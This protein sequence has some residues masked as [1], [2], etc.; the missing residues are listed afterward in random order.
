MRGAWVSWTA[1]V[2][3]IAVV[4]CS[5]DSSSSNGSGGGGGSGGTGTVEGGAG[6]AGAS[7]AGGS[8]GGDAGC[9]YSVSFGGPGAN[10]QFPRLA[11]DADGNLLV[12]GTFTGTVDFGGGPLS[13]PDATL[14]DGFLI[15]LDATG[16]HLWSQRVAASADAN[17]SKV[18]MSAEASGAVIVSFV[19]EGSVKIG[20]GP[21]LVSAGGT[22]IAVAKLSAAGEHEWS[23]QLGGSLEERGGAIAHASGG[24]ALHGHFLS[25]QLSFSGSLVLTNTTT[26]NS[27]VFAA[28]LDSDGN[29][30]WATNHGS[31]S[32]EIVYG[33]GN[34]DPAGN[35]IFMATFGGDLNLGSS[36]PAMTG[37]GSVIA[38]LS[39]SG[40]CMFRVHV[41]PQSGVSTDFIALWHAWSTS[42]LG[43]LVGGT[44]FGSVELVDAAGSITPLT[45]AGDADIAF[46]QIDTTG[47]VVRAASF[48]DNEYQEIGG[49][50]V[51]GSGNVY[52]ASHS[53]ASLD[54]GNGPLTSV[55]ERDVFIAK[56]DQTGA[57]VNARRFGDAQDQA[58]TTLAVD[59]D[60][61]L[62]ATGH[63]EGSIDFGNG[64]SLSAVGTNDLFVTQLCF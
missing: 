5:S 6:A 57:L 4:A 30:S 19:F 17:V 16:K 29:A 28:Q 3:V 9:G 27:D 46:V 34:V 55:G 25:D 14:A 31:G 61:R 43:T 24:A 18:Q 1:I 36:C 47:K 40:A 56:F 59:S 21:T 44:L 33:L 2:G 60:G 11:L 38:K 52:V 48:G 32:N 10:I 54:F 62:L 23:R 49:A 13:S 63:F 15:K 42:D 20:S 58:I 39:G 53:A 41:V 22:D 35:T 12:S 37:G 7:A 50:A 64:P 26:A 45:S 51:D 8:A